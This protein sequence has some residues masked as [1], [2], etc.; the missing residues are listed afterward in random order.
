MVLNIAPLESNEWK[1]VHVKM[2]IEEKIYD[3]I[4]TS[5]TKSGKSFCFHHSTEKSPQS[6]IYR[7]FSVAPG[8]ISI[9][10][11][12]IIFYFTLM[13]CMHSTLHTLTLCAWKWK[14]F[15]HKHYNKFNDNFTIVKT[16]VNQPASQ[17]HWRTGQQTNL[18]PLTITLFWCVAKAI[19]CTFTKK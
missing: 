15:R 10:P 16:N 14:S 6:I 3:V 11:N 9:K 8:Q 18:Y 2:Q 19:M 7:I 13:C 4:V 12:E 5:N 17:I 1:V